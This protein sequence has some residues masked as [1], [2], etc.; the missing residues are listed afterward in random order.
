[1]K[2]VKKID[3]TE[4]KII[5]EYDDLD[6]SLDITILDELED[7]IDIISIVNDDTEDNIDPR[8]N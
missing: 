6:G 4:Y 8:L 5:I 3:L 2:K 1:M 7:V